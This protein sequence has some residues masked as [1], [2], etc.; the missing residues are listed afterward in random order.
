M[1]EQVKFVIVG[2]GLEGLGIAYSLADRGVRDILVL[3][4]ATLCSGMTGKSSGVV[5]C[6]YGTP[7][8]AA[9]A[10]YGVDFLEQAGEVLG[11]DVG[12]RQCGY[13]V[14]V[15]QRNVEAMEANVA[16][17]QG[18][19]VDVELIDHARMARLWPGLYIDDFAA[20]AYEPRGGRGDAYLLGM[21]FAA[22]ARRMGVRIRQGALVTSLLQDGEDGVRGVE[23]ADGERVL[24][25][26]V[27]L[28]NGAWAPALTAP[29]GF[30]VPV[31]SQRAELVL[32][33]P[34]EPLPD[35]PVFSDLIGLQY[36]CR[37]PNGHVLVGNSDH[38]APEYIDPDHYADRAGD[39]TITRVV[40]RLGHRMPDMPDPRVAHSYAGGY[41]V[42]PDYNPIIGRAPVTGLFLVTGFSGHGFKIAPAVGRM[43]AEVLTTGR[44]SLAGVEPRDFRLSR[45][46]EGEPLLSRHPYE[47]AG[48]MR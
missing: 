35:V 18:L 29:L 1:S 12:L 36:L 46:A 17:Q 45:F 24:G 31:Q 27:I 30:E 4:R 34:G 2:G 6:H 28:A 3:E 25:G 26:S 42:T 21:A 47:G 14:G 43:V 5:R 48:A 15:A 22:A 7:S 8:L 19:G 16:L 38:A 23:L 20:F 37:E 13:A 11:E 40:E 10:K 33:D 39:A 44:T 9:M 32:V 41:D